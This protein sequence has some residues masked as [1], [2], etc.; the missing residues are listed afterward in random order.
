MGDPGRASSGGADKQTRRC[1]WC[2]GG[3]LTREH[4]VPQ[5]LAKVMS[6][7]AGADQSFESS[8]HVSDGVSVATERQSLSRRV[9][10]VVR[11]VCA[12]CNHG[13]MKH[14]EDHLKS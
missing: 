7:V 2:D 3:P 4:L 12:Q 8:F 13:W 5:W 6:D 14:L 11:S 9:E 10:I 1:F